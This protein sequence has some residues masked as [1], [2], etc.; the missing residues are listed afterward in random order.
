MIIEVSGKSATLVQKVS[1]TKKLAI[2]LKKR[3]GGIQNVKKLRFVG[4]I[5]GV[6]INS[7]FAQTIQ[8]KVFGVNQVELDRARNCWYLQFRVFWLLLPSFNLWKE[9]WAM[10]PVKF[11]I[12]LMFNKFLRSYVWSCLATYRTYQVSFYFWR[13]KPVL[14]NFKVPKYNNQDCSFVKSKTR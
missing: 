7:F 11:E 2:R 10:S 8:D 12:L 5:G 13:I 3:F 9:G 1:F 14:K 4:W 6:M